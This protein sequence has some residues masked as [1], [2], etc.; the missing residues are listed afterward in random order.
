MK[1]NLANLDA[2]VDRSLL[3]DAEG[4]EDE[5]DRELRQQAADVESAARVLRGRHY[6]AV[7][8]AELALQEYER[9]VALGDQTALRYLAGTLSHLGRHARAEQLYRHAPLGKDDQL[10]LDYADYLWD[11][12]R[13]DE[14]EARLRELVHH[15][16]AVAERVLADLV[17]ARSPDSEEAT[18]H[19]LAAILLGDALA[20]T[21]LGVH[22]LEQGRTL[23]AEFALRQASAE[24]D[25]LA[26][27][28][29]ERLFEETGS[30]LPTFDVPQQW[31]TVADELR[32]ARRGE[33]HPDW[34]ACLFAAQVVHLRG[35]SAPAD[36][37]AAFLRR[38]RWSGA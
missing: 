27:K 22:W 8:D 10:E 36:E 34:I 9:G 1:A 11:Q 7:G 17:S 14:A 31:Q 21:N 25:E 35:R 23:E 15:G 12:G 13:L 24:G 3:L 33:E 38:S 19:Y 6:R 5:A 2:L 26:A 29:L 30:K 4:H 20:V 37:I 18:A 32:T 28:S 16:N